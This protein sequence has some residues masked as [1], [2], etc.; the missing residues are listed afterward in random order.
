MSI[1][2]NRIKYMLSPQFD[3]YRTIY[4]QLS[5]RV[6]DIGFGTGFGMHL[7]NQSRVKT[8]VGYE[9][10]PDCVKL[11]G[12]LFPCGKFKFQLGDI[13][14]GVDDTG[15]DYITMIDVIEHIKDTKR[16]LMNVKGMLLDHGTVFIST[17]NRLSRYRKSDNHEREYAPNEF[18]QIL[19]RVFTNVELRGHDLK[20]LASDYENPMIAVCKTA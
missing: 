20:P 7:F 11:A 2:L 13:V 10:D 17:P 6:A 15:F 3:I 8:A 9:T 12:D 1:I 16:A 14:K 18:E 5:G 4:P 19:K